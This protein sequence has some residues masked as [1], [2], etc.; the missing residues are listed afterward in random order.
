MNFKIIKQE[1][2]ITQKCLR[3][4]YISPSVTNGNPE[5]ISLGMKHHLRIK[6]KGGD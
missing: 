3:C 5:K 2:R 1:G 6:H 4:D